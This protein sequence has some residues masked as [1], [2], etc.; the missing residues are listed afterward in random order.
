MN[1]AL[2][3]LNIHTHRQWAGKFCKSSCISGSGCDFPNLLTSGNLVSRDNL[4]A[5]PFHHETINKHLA[6]LKRLGVIKGQG[7]RGSVKYYID[8]G[9]FSQ[10]AGEF[11]TL[12]D[13]IRLL[14]PK[15]K[16]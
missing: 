11:T 5:I 4:S 10:M 6:D 14:E 8:E 13:S 15:T 12:F 3:Q 7:I 1:Y 9:L 16:E 2:F